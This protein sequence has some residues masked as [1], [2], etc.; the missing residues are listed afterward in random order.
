[1][2]LLRQ[3]LYTINDRKVFKEIHNATGGFRKLPKKVGGITTRELQNTEDML[4]KSFQI[5]NL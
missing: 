1:M 2:I 5:Q 4:L 3:K